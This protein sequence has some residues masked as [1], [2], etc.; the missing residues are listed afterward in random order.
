MSTSANFSNKDCDISPE[1]ISIHLPQ[2]QS[3]SQGLNLTQWIQKSRQQHLMA[4][5]TLPNLK[6][7]IIQ[8]LIP[9][10]Q[11]STHSYNDSSDHP[12]LGSPVINE[13]TPSDS[14]GFSKPPY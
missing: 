12:M 6:K 7:S 9:Q 11:E 4:S 8:T 3:P 10:V 5:T 2:H 14:P 13:P 1:V